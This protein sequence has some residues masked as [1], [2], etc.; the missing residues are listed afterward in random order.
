MKRFSYLL[1][2]LCLLSAGC[3]RQVDHEAIVQ[4]ISQQYDLEFGQG[5]WG[6]D[7]HP[8]E[9][10]PLLYE[11]VFDDGITDLFSVDTKHSKV[12]D[13]I[14]IPEL[15]IFGDGFDISDSAWILFEA[16]G[17]Y[18]CTT[19]RTFRVVYDSAYSL[20]NENKAD[21]NVLYHMQRTKLF[22]IRN[23]RFEQAFEADEIVQDFGIIDGKQ[24]YSLYINS[25]YEYNRKLRSV[26]HSIQ[27][28][29]SISRED[30]LQIIPQNEE[31]FRI[32]FD[33]Y[34]PG[35]GRQFCAIDRAVC[36]ASARDYVVLDKYLNCWQYSDGWVSE[37]L[38]S[39]FHRIDSVNP[40]LF[41]QAAVYTLAG[42]FVAS[43]IEEY[44]DQW[45]DRIFD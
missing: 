19:A 9:Q 37:T 28:G 22:A 10:S 29:D 4:Q 42:S 41:R 3:K 32:Y 8:S 43:S 2:V 27:Q 31:Q 17:N 15:C 36:E 7:I 35:N 38:L 5:M 14:H 25:C 21:T 44:G 33:D 34:T 16:R 39:N 45:Y 20:V 23:L 40:L 11:A 18:V 13:R 1:A 24:L 6:A 26:Y 30:L 12:V